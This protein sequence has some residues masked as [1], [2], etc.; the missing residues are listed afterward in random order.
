MSLFLDERS[1][2]DSQYIENVDNAIKNTPVPKAARF[3]CVLGGGGLHMYI[4]IY[5]QLN[6]IVN[7]K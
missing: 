6:L 1:E 7:F 5:T 4:C 3:V 2:I